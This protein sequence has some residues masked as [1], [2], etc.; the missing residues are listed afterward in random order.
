MVRLVVLAL[1]MVLLPLAGGG[2]TLGPAA[3]QGVGQ[4][5]APVAELARV[6]D[7]PRLFAILRDEGTDHG[8]DL[9]AELFPGKGGARW[10]GIV[11]AIHD[12]ARMEALALS[13][14]SEELA[15]RPD[16][17]TRMVGF[18]GTDP[19]VRIVALELAA[20]AAYRDDAVEDAARLAW[21]DMLAGNVGRADQIARLVEVNDLI[22]QNVAG[23]MNGNLAF[24]RGMIDGGAAGAQPPDSEMMADL[25]SQEPRIRADTEAWLLPYLALAYQPLTDDELEAYID[26]SG[27][28]EGRLLNRALFAAFDTLFNAL[29]RDLGLAAAQLLG[30]EDL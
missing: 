9:E 15:G 20:R 10:A 1:G 18:F 24:Y 11:A 29:S 2:P 3:A 16:D 5:V 25:W 13:R 28:P 7:L 26:F 6:L 14:L 30:S 22:E 27:T 12:P 8:A 21:E 4:A 23:A 19:G 17:V